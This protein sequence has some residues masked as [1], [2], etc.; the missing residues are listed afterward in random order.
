MIDILIIGS[1]PAGLTAAIYASRAQLSC[2]VAEKD[3]MGSGAISVTEQVD[4]YPGLPGISGYDLGEKLREHAEKLGTEIIT[5]EAASI[6]KTEN[7][8]VTQFK[9]GKEAASR[10]VI[11]AAGTS[12]RR[13]DIEG[14]KLLGVSYCAT[15]DG[16]FYGKKTVAVIG[17]GDTA[18]TDAL[19]LAKIACKVYLIHR[20]NEF[21]ANKT[22]VE[23]VKNI[24]NIEL[25]L[26]AEPVKILGDKNVGGIEL[27]VLGEQVTKSVDGIF[28]AIGS[29]P[30]T[31]ILNGL[32]ELDGCGYIKAD[33]SGKTSL[34]GFYAAGDVRT[35]ALRQVITACSDGANCVHSIEEY[36]NLRE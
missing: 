31:D 12:Y 18:L 17:G 20:R 34:E 11:Y 8:F 19:Y 29:V 14:G 25:V 33:E 23:R 2:L 6:E 4:N 36:L 35:K 3:F 1:G 7:G 26:S 15:C 22:L 5:A 28:A 30:N 10:T 21:R 9:N 16:A 27:D 32:T 13:L 24:P